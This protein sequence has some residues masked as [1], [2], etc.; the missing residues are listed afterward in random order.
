MKARGPAAHR[1]GFDKAMF[2]GFRNAII[3]HAFE[4]NIPCFLDEAEWRQLAIDI[5][6]GFGSDR[7]ALVQCMEDSYF[8]MVALPGVFVEAQNVLKAPPPDDAE[9]KQVLMDVAVR[10]H[11]HR[12]T[13]K[14]IYQDFQNC[15]NHSEQ[16]MIVKPS[17]DENDNIFPTVFD[18]SDIFI[19]TL[20]SWF[21]SFVGSI[22]I[23]LRELHRESMYIWNEECLAH[24]YISATEM[25]D[26]PD[27]V[28][29]S[30]DEILVE[31]EQCARACCMCV[32]YLSQS[33]YIGPFVLTYTL[34]MASRILDSPPETGW[35]RRRQMEIGK[36]FGIAKSQI[37]NTD[38]K[39]VAPGRGECS[40]SA[41]NLFSFMIG[42]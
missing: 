18:F 42:V 6:H 14:R 21:N 1:N 29:P 12:L 40:T 41:L 22:N 26:L 4:S 24:T 27:T 13:I 31:T 36:N 19:G 33:K 11:Q 37:W 7:T 9:H 8:H 10:A 28:P 35:I 16:W 32:D 23:I 25:T 17:P 3:V 20:M 39:F 38:V 2:L 15:L 5:D 30:L 34:R